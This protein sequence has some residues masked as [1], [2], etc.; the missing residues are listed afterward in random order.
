MYPKAKTSRRAQIVVL[1]VL[2]AAVY[3]GTCGWPALLDESDATNAEVG[4][5]II[6][7]RDWITPHTSYVPRLNKPLYSIGL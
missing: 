5:Q 7:N 2:A 3:I 4:Y 6:S 1:T